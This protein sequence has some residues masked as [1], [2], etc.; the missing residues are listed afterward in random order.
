MPASMPCFEHRTTGASSTAMPALCALA[1]ALALALGLLASAPARAHKASDAYLTLTGDASAPTLRVDLALRDLDAA[2]DLDADGDGRLVWREVRAAWPAIEAYVRQ[3]TQLQGCMLGSAA[4]ALERRAD[5]A[6]AA[7]G[8]PANCAQD[9]PAP[10]PQIQY[11]A[12]HDVDPTHRGIARLALAGQAEAVR[13]LDPNA[14]VRW[15]ADPAARAPQSASA[16]QL[17]PGPASDPARAPASATSPIPAA[18]TVLPPAEGDGL[19]REGVHHIVTGYD[20]VLFLLCL[21]LPAVMRRTPSGWKP[22]Q[23]LRDA[24]WP[25]VGIVTAFTVAHSITLAAAALGWV[26]L[27]ASFVEPAIAAT[28]I[29]AAANNLWPVFGGRVVWVTFAF[30]LLHGFGFAGVLAELNLPTMDFALALLQFNVGLELG[31]LAIVVVAVSLM[32][33]V[34]RSQRYEP[35]VIRG[36]S[37]AAASLALLWLIER[38]AKVS[39]LPW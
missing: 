15:N 32:F 26:A 28:I 5:G 21:L 35:W 8:F 38:T 22:A 7:L 36:G 4:T 20:H 37:T 33:L 19:V 2:L 34:R 1:W 13:V 29:L 14:P 18:G 16:P 23:R 24:L 30:G 27:P 31:Q 17:A 12:F 9:A 11:T 3:H 25:V 39:L 10:A 6:Y